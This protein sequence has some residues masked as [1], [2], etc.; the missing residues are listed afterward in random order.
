MLLRILLTLTLIS[1]SILASAQ[2]GKEKTTINRGDL[3]GHYIGSDADLTVALELSPY[4]FKQ[5]NFNDFVTIETF[6]QGEMGSWKINGSML[7]LIDMDLDTPNQQLKIQ[8]DGTLL[9]GPDELVL[10]PVGPNFLGMWFHF[11]RTL[12]DASKAAHYRSDG[13]LLIQ[14]DFTGGK[15]PEYSDDALHLHNMGY[16]YESGT[17]YMGGRDEGIFGMTDEIPDDEKREGL[18]D[19]EKAYEYYLK[20][21]EKGYVQS[22]YNL[23]I[24]HEKGRHVAKDLSKAVGWYRKAADYGHTY[25]ENALA[26][27]LYT[28]AE[29]V[30]VNE[31]EAAKYWRSA[32]S[33]GS[34]AAQYNLAS[35]LS[36]NPDSTDVDL[37]EARDL[38][39]R[40]ALRDN[41]AAFFSLVDILI[42]ESVDWKDVNHDF[43]AV[44]IHFIIQSAYL[45]NPQAQ[46]YL[47]RLKQGA[48]G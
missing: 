13:I 39:W 26:H 12:K 38:F 22:M 33:K 44:L 36:F 15:E 4:V 21:A 20:A 1:F 40:A 14:Q 37:V 23:A 28:G 25:S 10:K 45:G 41:S 19:Y 9:Y 30:P 8:G 18:I 24:Y 31:A 7:E 42:D 3:V 27:Y 46:D 48:E 5:F 29:G 6:D 2:E 32:A 47:E 11:N 43:K 16:M 35:F 34:A 17:K